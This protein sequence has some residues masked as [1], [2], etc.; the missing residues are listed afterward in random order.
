MRLEYTLS[1]QHEQEENHFTNQYSVPAVSN[2]FDN[3]IIWQRD[4]ENQIT[5]DYSDPISENTKLELGYDGSFNR[6]EPKFTLENYDAG[7]QKFITDITRSNSFIHREKLNAVYGTW[8]QSSGKLGWMAGLRVEYSAVRSDLVSRD[9]VIDNNYLKIYPTLHLSYA[10]KT[11]ELQL[12]YSRRVHR[13]EADD[14]NPFPEYMDPRNLRAGNPHLLPEIIHSIEMGYKWQD[15]KYSFVPSLYYRYKQNGFTQLVSKI[16]DST[17]LTTQQNL[18]SDVS[19]GT[20]LIFSAKP[21]KYIQANLSTNLFWQ[22]IDGEDLGF[23]G[24]RSVVSMSSNLN[25]TIHLA[26]ATMFQLSGNYRSARLTPQGKSFGSVVCNAGVRQDLFHKKVS[27]ILTGSDLFKSLKEKREIDTPVL[28][29]MSIGTR[30][31]RIFYLGLSWH[32]GSPK[33]PQEEKMQFD[34]NL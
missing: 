15:D 2:S 10:L 31:A 16:N 13:P 30:N 9:S 12:N 26:P 20:E 21:A 17:F 6:Y 23:T 7:L 11:G 34:N 5:L 22:Q 24:K 27:A 29:Q 25:C 18:S 8:Q 33:K 1:R 19:A 4:N 14:L 28:K 3:S 32:F